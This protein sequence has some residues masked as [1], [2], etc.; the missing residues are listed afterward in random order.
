MCQE[1]RGNL[2]GRLKR[3]GR[4]CRGSHVIYRVSKIWFATL[5]ISH[6]W[7]AASN[8]LVLNAVPAGSMTIKYV[9]TNVSFDTSELGVISLVRSGR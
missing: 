9:D 6:T 2:F 1:I 4:V 3:I 8:I 7:Q 5:S